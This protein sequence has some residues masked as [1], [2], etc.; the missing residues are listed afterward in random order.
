MGWL[1]MC[2]GIRDNSARRIRDAEGRLSSDSYDA[3]FG[4]SKIPRIEDY[5]Q[6]RRTGYDVFVNRYTSESPNSIKTVASSIDS[7]HADGNGSNKEGKKWA[8]QESNVQLRRVEKKWGNTNAIPPGDVIS[9]E[10]RPHWSSGEQIPENNVVSRET[11]SLRKS[12]SELLMETDALDSSTSRFKGPLALAAIAAAAERAARSHR[13]HGEGGRGRKNI[14]PVHLAACDQPSRSPQSPHSISLSSAVS[15]SSL[16]K[17]H[18]EASH[19]V[20]AFKENRRRQMSER[21]SNVRSNGSIRKIF[22][23]SRKRPFRRAL[24]PVLEVLSLDEELRSK[25]KS[26]VSLRDLFTNDLPQA[27]SERTS[28][29]SIPSA[30][31]HQQSTWRNS[32]AMIA[33]ATGMTS[34]A[35]S[36]EEGADC[37][38]VENLQEK[39]EA[40]GAGHSPCPLSSCLSEF[41]EGRSQETPV[42]GSVLGE[43]GTINGNHDRNLD[44]GLDR[45]SSP[46]RGAYP[47]GTSSGPENLRLQSQPHT[48]SQNLGHEPHDDVSLLRTSVRDV[49]VSPEVFMSPKT[50]NSELNFT[51]IMD[52][53]PEERPILGSLADHWEAALTTKK[54]AWDGKGIPNSTHKYREDQKVMWHSA[55]F[56]ERLVQALATQEASVP[57]RRSRSRGLVNRLAA[58]RSD[59][60]LQAH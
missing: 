28:T 29:E 15:V 20:A 45:A 55:S 3:R 1:W 7:I 6:P 11:S 44:E 4:S 32:L 30:G 58:G 8:H 13:Q 54:S 21:Q 35:L 57:Q 36:T 53:N 10:F 56:E 42:D 24:S 22:R 17:K 12:F 47:E 51:R 26:D 41:A 39:S 33:K 43:N 19:A 49:L 9:R 16:S 23:S 60:G 31:D 48:G 37:V 14:Q 2:L 18:L 50:A 34:E 59:T 25:R 40:A 5:L 52:V 38:D 46:P 27:P